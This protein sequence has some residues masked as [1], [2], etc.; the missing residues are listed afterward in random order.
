MS[1]FACLVIGPDPEK[2]LA[3]YHEFECT[4]DDNEYVQ[5]VDRT[6]EARAEFTGE[7]GR[8][9]YAD[10]SFAEFAQDY[11]GWDLVP[12]GSAPD[13]SGPHKYGYVRLDEQGEVAQCIDRTNPN[14]KWDWY[15]LGGRWTG[16]FTLKP[17][18]TGERGKPGLTTSP[19]KFGTADMARKGDIDFE[20]MRDEAAIDAYATWDKAQRFTEGETWEPWGTVRERFGEDVDAAR[21]YYWAQPP[22]KA[23]RKAG[24]YEVDHLL[25]DREGFADD[26]RLE[27]GVTFAVVKDGQWYERGKMGWFGSVSD[28]KDKG[29]WYMQFC[30]LLSELPDDT[31]LS[32]W[33][34]H[35]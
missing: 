15:E 14:A 2:Q 34:L 22:V 31:L 35:I 26:A 18:R 30:Q 19:A 27:A 21:D 12:H 17:G 11:Y 1:H 23:L 10:K 20:R 33:D 7:Y 29:E 24:Y 13:L 4:G 25:C 6:E 5:N 8:T 28:E 16:F 32:V 3:P 9:H